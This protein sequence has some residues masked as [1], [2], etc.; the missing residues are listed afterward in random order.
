MFSWIHLYFFIGLAGLALS[1]CLT[2]FFQYIAERTDFMDRPRG[3]AHKGHGKATPLLGGAAM[4]TAWIL[5]I[6]G[7]ILLVKN[8][9]LPQMAALLSAHS[10][11]GGDKA[12]C[13]GCRAGL[14]KRTHSGARHR[15][16][17][18]WRSLCRRHSRVKARGAHPKPR[19]HALCV[20]CRG[21]LA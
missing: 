18:A 19:L 21:R 4:F 9:H 7:G 8:N 5:C 14:V 2:P 13:Q 15:G 20:P 3:E 16:H 6:G 10:R 12:R 1:L 17:S 11:G